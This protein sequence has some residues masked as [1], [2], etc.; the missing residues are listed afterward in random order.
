MFSYD[1]NFGFVNTIN[2]KSDSTLQEGSVLSE[3]MTRQM[4]LRA[5]PVGTCRAGKPFPNQ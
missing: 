4:N 1:M 2:S 3:R 5:L